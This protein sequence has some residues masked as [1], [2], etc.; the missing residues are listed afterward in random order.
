M[1]ALSG[2]RFRSGSQPALHSGSS[3]RARAGEDVVDGD[4]DAVEVVVAVA[5][6][7]DDEDDAR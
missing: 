1:Q 4:D 7:V 6:A 3:G 5:V 2:P